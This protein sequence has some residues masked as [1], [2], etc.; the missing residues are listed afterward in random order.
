MDPEEE[1]R[2]HVTILPESGGVPLRVELDQA[3]RLSRVLAQVAKARSG[4]GCLTA[5]AVGSTPKR[6]ARC[7][8]R[9]RGLSGYRVDAGVSYRVRHDRYRRPYLAADRG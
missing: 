1:E 7:A 9:S 3:M 2:P 6:A 4:V 5:D 8:A